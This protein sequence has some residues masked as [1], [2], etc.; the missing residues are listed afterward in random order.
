MSWRIVG[1]QG[2]IRK[3]GLNIILICSQTELY[4]I[5]LLQLLCVHVHLAW[6]QGKPYV[7]LKQR[8]PGAQANIPPSKHDTFQKIFISDGV[9]ILLYDIGHCEQPT[10][11]PCLGAKLTGSLWNSI[12]SPI[13]WVSLLS[14]SITARPTSLIFCGLGRDTSKCNSD[15]NQELKFYYSQSC[16]LVD[17]LNIFI[18][19][20]RVAYLDNNRSLKKNLS[21][22]VIKHDVL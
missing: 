10:F 16:I 13:A 8:W 4:I 1:C 9:R 11:L 5:Q 17:F 19:L 6:I 14:V 3:L 2:L 15:W 18:A 7:G 21:W 20:F 12:L 22:K